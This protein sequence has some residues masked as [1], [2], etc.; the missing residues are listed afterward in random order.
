MHRPQFLGGFLAAVIVDTSCPWVILESS[1]GNW[2]GLVDVR[3]VGIL[4][5]Y[6]CVMFFMKDVQIHVQ[7]SGQQPRNVSSEGAW[8]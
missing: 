6:A 8:S 5:L 3:N 4:V 2:I 7:V 1:Q